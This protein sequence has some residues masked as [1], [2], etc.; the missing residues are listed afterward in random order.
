MQ[1]VA[2]FPPLPF[3]IDETCD[4][5]PSPFAPMSRRLRSRHAAGD[6]PF[7]PYAPGVKVPRDVRRVRVRGSVTVIPNDAFA[8]CRLLKQIVFPDG[9]REI[10][11]WAFDCC[12][13]L[14]RVDFPS[15]LR[16]IG[17]SAFLCCTSLREVELPAGLAVLGPQAF[18]ECCY[19]ERV[20]LPATLAAVGD[21]AFFDCASLASARLPDGIRAVGHAAFHNCR[22]LEDVALPATVSAVGGNAFGQCAALRRVALRGGIQRIEAGAFPPCAA[23]P[24]ERVA[25][26]SRAL[27]VVADE[28]EEEEGR[29]HFH[30]ATGGTLPRAA[31]QRDDAALVVIAAE[32]FSSLHPE[33]KGDVQAAVAGVLD[34]EMGWD[35]QRARLRDVLAPYEM[36]HK[37]EI[38]T[39]LELGLWKAEMGGVDRADLC[40][41]ETCRVNC[42]ADGIIP[43]VLPFL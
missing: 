12:V 27:V 40:V 19:L 20:G 9:L 33:E 32:C 18:G 38:T 41:R 42:G 13:S 29:R 2:R 23:A 6:A 26:P 11:A 14:E 31:L 17:R 7:F 5:H 16:K 36:R 15:T 39:I 1:G 35:E 21:A 4:D 43:Y 34:L 30:W 10:G 37:E 28:E 8:H 25:T 24:L 22:A 3:R